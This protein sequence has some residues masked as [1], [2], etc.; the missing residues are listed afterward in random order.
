MVRR[1]SLRTEHDVAITRGFVV[2]PA[3]SRSRR[4]DRHAKSRRKVT[5]MKKALFVAAGVLF[6]GCAT[7]S[8]LQ[9]V[10]GFHPPQTP[11]GYTRFISP[12]TRNIAPG[13]DLEMCQWVAGP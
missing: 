2:L 3:A 5:T 8:E 12:I 13:A 6:V 1:I 7:E 10:A 11:E 9:Y 4:G